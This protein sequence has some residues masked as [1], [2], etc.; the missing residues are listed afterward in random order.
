MMV[1]MNTNLAPSYHN[2]HVHFYVFQTI[3]SV[4]KISTL[5]QNK[6]QLFVYSWDSLK[7]QT[8]P[9]HGVLLSLNQVGIRNLFTQEYFSIHDV[10]LSSLFRRFSHNKGRKSILWQRKI[11][12]GK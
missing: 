12:D 4:F 6:I 9:K 1:M 2:S 8:I 5:L 3:T 7:I 11:N 10:L